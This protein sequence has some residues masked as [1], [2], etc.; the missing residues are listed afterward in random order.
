MA[1]KTAIPYL[2]L[3][4]KADEAVPFYE[5]ALGAKVTTLMRF[6]DSMPDCPDALKNQVMHAALQLGDATIYL[7]DGSPEGAPTP[8]GTVQ[9]AVE[10]DSAAQAHGSFD[11]LSKGGTINHPFSD[12][13]WGGLFGAL[14]D[15]FGISWLFTST[16]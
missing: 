10:F 12:A 3:N 1:I 15:R 5:Q 11:G 13:P 4:G 6:G 8:G 16:K 2:I 9:V 14:R 7:S